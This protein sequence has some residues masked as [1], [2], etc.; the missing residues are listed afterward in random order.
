MTNDKLI[1]PNGNGE[2]HQ[3]TNDEIVEITQLTETIPQR[4]AD[5]ATAIKGELATVTHAI[6]TWERLAPQLYMMKKRL[7]V[8]DEIVSGKRNIESIAALPSSD[9]QPEKKKRG[10]A[11]GTKTFVKKK[12]DIL[13]DEVIEKIRDYIA[14]DQEYHKAKDIYNY[15]RS[16][17]II[18]PFSGP[19]P[20]H[21]F[22]IALSRVDQ[23]LIKYNEHYTI[24]AWGLPDYGTPEHE[25]RKLLVSTNSLRS[26]KGTRV[27]SYGRGEP[28][29]A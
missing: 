20:E 11:K 22:A 15:L 9:A 27:S 8:I 1:S 10:P 21:A 13:T 18:A 6:D 24:M 5:T 19:K 14:K 12:S 28:V 16:Q 25:R 7:T 17:E 3:V 26:E 23:D 2:T 29:T 4:Y